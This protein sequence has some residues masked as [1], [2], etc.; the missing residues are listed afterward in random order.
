MIRFVSKEHT[1]DHMI[2]A[3]C[4]QQCKAGCADKGNTEPL[5][6][7]AHNRHP[8]YRAVT[9]ISS[10]SLTPLRDPSLA[11]NAHWLYISTVTSCTQ[12]WHMGL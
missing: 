10:T 3:V 2:Q 8:F 4:R 9:W 7:T 5:T 6:F 12:L 1:D 11:L